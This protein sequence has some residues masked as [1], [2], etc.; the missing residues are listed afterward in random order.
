MLYTRGAAACPR[1]AIR[2]PFARCFALVLDVSR[3]DCIECV[4]GTNSRCSGDSVEVTH[5]HP[6]RRPAFRRPQLSR[7]GS[8]VDGQFGVGRGSHPH[9]WKMVEQRSVEV[10][11]RSTDHG[12]GERQKEE[13]RT[14]RRC[15]YAPG[16]SSQWPWIWHTWCL[17]AGHGACGTPR[18]TCVQHKPHHSQV[19]LHPQRGCSVGSRHAQP[20]PGC[21]STIGSNVLRGSIKRA[22][23]RFASSANWSSGARCSCAKCFPPTTRP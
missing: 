6:S 4:H 22:G 9:F 15:A 12:L 11:R 1:R 23:C 21:A 5:S 20:R 14:R 13:V 17:G 3:A 2:R 19:W 18:T 7:H 16:T 10:H 8:P